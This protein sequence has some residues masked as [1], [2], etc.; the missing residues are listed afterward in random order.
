[1]VRP[2]L[3]RRGPGAETAG[4]QLAHGRSARSSASKDELDSRRAVGRLAHPMHG[5]RSRSVVPLGTGLI[6]LVCVGCPLRPEPV[7]GE[8]VEYQD[9]P[10]HGLAFP[11][12]RVSIS[13]PAGGLAI[14]TDSLSDT[15]SVV[16]PSAHQR[17]AGLPVGRDPLGVDGPVAI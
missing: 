4:R 8:T 16:D 13:V 17:V 11:D 3:A 7:P 6:A 5:T 15:L 9:L 1:D 10:Y 12:R 14:V 2:S